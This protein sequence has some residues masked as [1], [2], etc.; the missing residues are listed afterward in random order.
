LPSTAAVAKT[1]SSGADVP[2]PIIRKV[3]MPQCSAA[4]A[5]P[6]TNLSA[7]HTRTI[8][9]AMIAP[10][11]RSVRAIFLPN[12]GCEIKVAMILS[13]KNGKMHGNGDR[14]PGQASRYMARNRCL[15][16]FDSALKAEIIVT[17][18]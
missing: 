4:A 2:T 12:R 16:P 6:S 5:G 11:T 17:S 1:A 3:G 18:H 8:K 7:L 14:L 9:P 15:L 10:V 13:D